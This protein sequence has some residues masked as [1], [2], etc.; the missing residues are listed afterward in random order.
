MGKRDAQGYGGLAAYPATVREPEADEGVTMKPALAPLLATVAALSVVGFNQTTAY[1]DAG[2][3][4]SAGTSGRARACEILAENQGRSYAKGLECA[5]LTVTVIGPSLPRNF[6][7][8]EVEGTGLLPGSSVYLQGFVFG[9]VA[10]D[11]TFVKQNLSP[12]DTTLTF[13]ATTLSGETITTT[14]VL[15]C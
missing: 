7:T 6:C 15:S 2:V 14:L 13:S 5:A 11:G 10:P 1:A 3:G 4:P 9:T 12:R 8:Y